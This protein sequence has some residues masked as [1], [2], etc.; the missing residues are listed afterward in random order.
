[1][2]HMSKFLHYTL[3]DHLRRYSKDSGTF[4]RQPALCP[5][6][7]LPCLLNRTRYHQHKRNDSGSICRTQSAHTKRSG[8]YFF[9]IAALP[10][11]NR[12]TSPSR[13]RIQQTPS[14]IKI[15]SPFKRFHTRSHSLLH[16]CSKF[17][18]HTR[19]LHL[20]FTGRGCFAAATL[21]ASSA[22]AS[23]EIS[24]VKAACMTPR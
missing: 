21:S 3:P 16:C 17:W 18:L 6:A 13:F 1:M 20:T 9:A 23:A 2:P 7:A 14:S 10:R 8:S 19:S 22:S 24:C 11:R 4:P 15:L 12:Q 5:H